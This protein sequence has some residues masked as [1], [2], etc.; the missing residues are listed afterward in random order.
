[1]NVNA[2]GSDHLPEIDLSTGNSRRPRG[3]ENLINLFDGQGHHFLK[4]IPLDRKN[5]SNAGSEDIK[6]NIFQ[7][8]DSIR[9]TTDEREVFLSLASALHT[10]YQKGQLDNMLINEITN[11][12]RSVYGKYSLIQSEEPT[13][14]SVPFMFVKALKRIVDGDNFE[15]FKKL[16]SYFDGRPDKQLDFIYNAIVPPYQLHASCSCFATAELIILWNNFPSKW[17]YFITGV[18]DFDQANFNVF[19]YEVNNPKLWKKDLI[20]DTSRYGYK[21]KDS[22]AQTYQKMV[23]GTASFANSFIDNIAIFFRLALFVLTNL[24]LILQIP[25]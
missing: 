24:K 2:A 9:S 1:M 22:P 19:R 16:I 20:V 3:V 18:I 8:I 15:T 11:H 4:C 17:M 23:S 12:V 25:N 10:A 21:D 7:I 5:V 14:N 6:S 13:L